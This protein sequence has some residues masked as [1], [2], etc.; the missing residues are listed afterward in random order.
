[1]NPWRIPT[2]LLAVLVIPGMVIGFRMLGRPGGNEAAFVVEIAAFV[3]SALM[4]WLA[5][6]K[7]NLSWAELGLARP[8][9]LPTAGLTG[10]GLVAVAAGLA[11]CLGAFHLLGLSYG[12]GDGVERPMWL[13][14]AM[15]VR[16]GVVEE[17][18]FR[19]IAI[20]HTAS[21][22][23]SKTLG[24]LLPML[25]FGLLHFSQGLTGIIIATVTGGII[26]ALYLWKRNLWANFAI[27]FIVDFVPNILLP[28]LG[29]GE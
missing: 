27:H 20:D 6:A 3:L 10:L 28:L 14:T 17:L 2:L 15:I 12:E 21:L 5:R 4:M 1:M 24:W 26:T 22:T 16:A 19:S 7:Q 18:T 23:G 29:V 25:L 13:L 9:L 11:A 8:K